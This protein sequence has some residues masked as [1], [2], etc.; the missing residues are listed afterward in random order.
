MKKFDVPFTQYV[1][2]PYRNILCVKV[3]FLEKKTIQDFMQSHT[4][5]FCMSNETS[6]RYSNIIIIHYETRAIFFSKKASTRSN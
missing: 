6:A 4:V 5:D 1:G 3:I 2:N